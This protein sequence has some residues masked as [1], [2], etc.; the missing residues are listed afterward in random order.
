MKLYMRYLPGLPWS[1]EGDGPYGPQRQVL[2]DL[3]DLC[4]EM[5]FTSV[6]VSC[7][8]IAK[9][10]CLCEELCGRIV[11]GEKREPCFEINDIIIADLNFVLKH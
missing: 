6:C 9:S 5:G 11:H 8:Y 3:F 2:I 10:F 1:W 4:K 7:N